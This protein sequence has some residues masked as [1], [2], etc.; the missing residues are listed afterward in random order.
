LAEAFINAMEII[1]KTLAE[2]AGLDR[3]DSLVSLR[4]QVFILRML[5]MSLDRS[6]LNNYLK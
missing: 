6:S 3:I 4:S 2:N 1:P 5:E